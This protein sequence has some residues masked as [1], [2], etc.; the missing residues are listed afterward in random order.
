MCIVGILYLYIYILW[1]HSNFGAGLIFV[2]FAHQQ[3]FFSSKNYQYDMI[4]FLFNIITV[5]NYVQIQVLYRRTDYT[6]T[7]NLFIC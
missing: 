4:Y 7:D 1:P 2:T 6:G 5:T 3:T